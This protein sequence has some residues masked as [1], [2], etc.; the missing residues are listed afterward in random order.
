[1]RSEYDCDDLK[2]VRGKYYRRL[3]KEG[4]NGGVLDPDGA[5]TFRSSLA[6]NETLRSLLTMSE[7]M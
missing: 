1:M 5:R 4:S 6:L 7:T 2:A 3:L